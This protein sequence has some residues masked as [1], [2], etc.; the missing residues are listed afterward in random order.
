M[1]RRNHIQIVPIWLQRVDRPLYALALLVFAEQ[2]A[3]EE[4]TIVTKTTVRNIGGEAH[5]A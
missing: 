4:S 1:K 2:L 3:Q 5:H